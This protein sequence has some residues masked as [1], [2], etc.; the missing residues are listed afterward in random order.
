MVYP[1]QN[2]SRVLLISSRDVFH[3]DLR[4]ILGCPLDIRAPQESSSAGH[5]SGLSTDHRSSYVIE[6]AHEA[7]EALAKVKQAIHEQHPY[8][9]AF[10]EEEP[11]L[12][13]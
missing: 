2:K 4:T 10:V 7:S 1:D 3:D 5:L 8:A 11:S 13:E 6:S 12:H 9:V